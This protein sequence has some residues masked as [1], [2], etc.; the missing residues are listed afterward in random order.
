M[1]P[2]S[3]RFPRSVS[4]MR[5]RTAEHVAYAAWLRSVATAAD[6]GDRKA[7][8]ELERHLSHLAK[9]PRKGAR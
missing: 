6:A 1:K 4:A 9:K 2:P 7:T 3:T 5:K 8:A